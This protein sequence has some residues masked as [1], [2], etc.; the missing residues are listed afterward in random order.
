LKLL[1]LWGFKMTFE[2]IKLRKQI[3]TLVV[4]KRLSTSL[5]I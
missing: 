1:K 3:I 4:W 5:L 2:D